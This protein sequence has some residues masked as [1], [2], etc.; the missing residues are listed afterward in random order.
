MDLMKVSDKINLKE[1]ID[2]GKEK[3]VGIILW[4]GWYAV[5]QKMEEAFNKYSAMGV[6]GFKIDFMDRDDQPMVSSLYAIAKKA[7]EYKLIVDYHGM[8]KPTG[9]QRTWPN[10]VNFEGLIAFLMAPGV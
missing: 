1:I 5:D 4:A 10:V 9:L 2:H 8:Y 7:A 6:K 3:N